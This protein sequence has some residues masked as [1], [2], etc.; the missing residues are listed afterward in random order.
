MY[1][2]NTLLHILQNSVYPTSDGV[3]VDTEIVDSTETVSETVVTGSAIETDIHNISND[4][5]LIMVFVLLTF[6]SACL[7]SWRAH[8]LKGVK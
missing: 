8:S 1:E 6:A 3:L 7:R 2:K 4:V 5:H